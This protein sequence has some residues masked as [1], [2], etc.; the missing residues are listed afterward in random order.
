MGY[1]TAGV[2]SG[3]SG[4]LGGGFA[5]IPP[6]QVVSIDA[7][8]NGPETRPLATALDGNYPNPFNPTTRIRYSLE[9]AGS[10]R[11]TVYD[12]LGREVAVLVDG[13]RASGRHEATFDAARLG[14]GMYLY[15][16]MVDGREVATR[17]MTLLK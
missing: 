15:R 12:L 16:L 6:G 9:Q 13:T 8:D 10:V 3:T 17:R 11:L 4:F 1:V 7:P 14:S 5:Y 2:G